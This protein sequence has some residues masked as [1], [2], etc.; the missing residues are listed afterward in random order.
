MKIWSVVHVIVGC[1][2]KVSSLL[3]GR[4]RWFPN[5]LSSPL[6]PPISRVSFLRSPLSSLSP[7][8]SNLSISFFSFYFPFAD[9]CYRS[10]ALLNPIV[11]I[12]FRFT[13]CPKKHIVLPNL[14]LTENPIT[15]LKQSTDVSPLSWLCVASEC[16]FL[17]I[18]Y[19]FDANITKSLL[20]VS[21]HKRTKY[22]LSVLI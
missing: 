18:R 12:L 1:D 11:L 16:F 9:F 20:Y 14:I 8:S 15:L 5:L 6:F 21:V 13:C 10:K 2:S 19:E 22:K 3:V 4:Y 7:I 17:Q